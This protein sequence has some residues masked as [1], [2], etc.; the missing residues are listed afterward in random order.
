MLFHSSGWP[1][2]YTFMADTTSC[3]GSLPA[4]EFSDIIC[5]SPKS[6]NLSN[7]AFARTCLLAAQGDKTNVETEEGVPSMAIQAT[8]KIW[9]NGKLIPWNEA[10][11][12]IMSHVVN[13]GS[14]VFEGI[15]CYAQPDGPAIFRLRDTC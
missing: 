3:P 4:E 13:Y 1:S 6:F 9:H 5:R 2:K 10:Q 7:R 11:I 14:S 12:H 15:R 8:E